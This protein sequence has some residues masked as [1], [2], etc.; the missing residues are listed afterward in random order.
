MATPMT[1][2]TC[3]APLDSSLLVLDSEDET[4]LKATTRID[5]TQ[6]LRDH[7]Q[8]V[9][10]EAYEVS[11]SVDERKSEIANTLYRCS[12]TVQLARILSPGE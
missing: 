12:L 5:D 10:R 11:G 8:L 3:P 2:R 6:K 4:F 1:C 9:A 7:I